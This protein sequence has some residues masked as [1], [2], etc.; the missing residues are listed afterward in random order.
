M[1]TT[2][3]IRYQGVPHPVYP[4]RAIPAPAPTVITI[5]QDLPTPVMTNWGDCGYVAAWIDVRTGP[6]DCGVSAVYC[7][8]F[9]LRVTSEVDG[10]PRV[11]RPA[12]VPEWTAQMPAVHAAM[13]AALAEAERTRPDVRRSC[14]VNREEMRR[15]QDVDL[16][17]GSVWLDSETGEYHELPPAR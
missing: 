16:A 6:D 5:P 13:V 15:A 12:E 8:Q 1:S 2:I 7:P 3:T 17:M 14:E 4:E 9:G 10:Y 11:A